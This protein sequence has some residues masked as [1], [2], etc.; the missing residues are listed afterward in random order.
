MRK[1]N[2]ELPS[3]NELRRIIASESQR[4]AVRFDYLEHNRE[5]YDAYRKAAQE[6]GADSSWIDDYQ[7]VDIE[8]LDRQ[9]RECTD[10]LNASI[11]ALPAYHDQLFDALAI[12]QTPQPADGIFVFGS[13]SD[14]RIKKAVELYA[15]AY[16]SKLYLSGHRPFYASDELPEAERMK[17]FAIDRGVPPENIITENRSITLPDNVKTMLDDF[18]NNNLRPKKL[19]IIATTYILRRAAMDWYRFTPWGIEIIPVSAEEPDVS[20]SLRRATWWRSEKG[21]RQLLNEYVKIVFEHKMS[22]EQK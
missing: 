14:A 2:L 15:Y 13:P 7:T 20:E 6:I 3:A 16:A 1:S 5:M 8:E 10:R 9:V 4:S 19:I 22:L 18:E 12:G 21:R 11:A 17:Q